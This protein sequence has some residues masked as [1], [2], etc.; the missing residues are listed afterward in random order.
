M[1]PGATLLILGIGLLSLLGAPRPAQALESAP[2]TSERA[3]V[4]LASDSDSVAPGQPIRLG[5][6]FKLAPG[7]HIYWSNPG[8]AGQPPQLDLTLPDGARAGA[9]QFPTPVRMIDGPVGSFVY[10]GEVLLPLTVTLPASG[11]SLP[12]T[13]KASWLVCEKICVPEEGSFQLEIPAG[14]ATPSPQAPL[15]AAAAVRLPRPSPFAATIAPDGTLAI[16]GRGLSRATVA[17]AWF[18]PANWGA[19]THAA[20][21]PV[22][23]AD[24]SVALALKPGQA[25]DPKQRLAGILVLKDPS[26]AET[27]LQLDAKPGGKPAPLSVGL[28]QTLV[29]AFLGGLILNLM[30]CVFPVLAIKAIAIARLSGHEHGAVRA[31]AAFYTLGVL[32]AFA[33]LA[34]LLMALRSAGAAVGWGFQFQSPVFVVA[35]SWLLFL[36]GLNFSGVFTIGASIM[37]VGQGLAGRTGHAGSFFTGLLAVLVATPCTTPFM[38]AALAAALTAPAGVAL[39]IFL[40]LGLGLAAPYLLLALVPSLA[41]LLPR[42]GAWMERLKQGLAFPMYGAAAWL[43]WVVSQQAGPDGVL[44][45]VAGLV[46]LGFAGWAYGAGQE[47]DGGWRRAAQGAATLALVAA[48]AVLP[49]IRMAP[50]VAEAGAEPYSAA[51][52]AALQAEGKPVFVNMTAA[53]CVTCLVNEKVALSAAPVQAAF[54]SRHVTYLKGDWT[55]Q[56]PAITAFLR[57]HDRD[58]VPLYAYFPPGA[59]EPRLL[60]QILTEGTVLDALD[61]S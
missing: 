57:D 39:G 22:S 11:G 18:F 58:G 1:R 31:E 21:Q 55:R 32:I 53:W 59:K 5:L 13:G 33:G 24:G 29:F 43:A 34:A 50:P 54:A 26:G 51:R 10:Q 36:V 23:V 30:P 60:P 9:L 14:H 3:T 38:G 15:F 4:T 35:I 40:T 7:W 52:L 25:F 42:P 46:L 16:A 56:D 6:H 37:G 20:A 19:V 45:C 47:S 27:A 8:D 41:R 12:V 2:V 49:Q 28:L 48:L 17:D 44:A 61:P